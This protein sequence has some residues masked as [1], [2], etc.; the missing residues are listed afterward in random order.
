V[1][2]RKKKKKA[3]QVTLRGADAY[4]E[5]ARFVAESAMTLALDRQKL[6]FKGGVLS[7]MAAFGSTLV[8]RVHRGTFSM[9]VKE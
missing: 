8:Q 7:P 6:R 4:E 3:L 2:Q 5:T 1:K 9:S